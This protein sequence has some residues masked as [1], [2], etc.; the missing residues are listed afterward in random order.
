MSSALA[1]QTKKYGAITVFDLL[2]EGSLVASLI[3]EGPLLVDYSRRRIFQDLNTAIEF[4][5][6]QI[7]PHRNYGVL[8]IGSL[9][10]GN[11]FVVHD[12]CCLFP[13]L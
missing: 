1:V 7:A 8:T 4:Y 5:L 13:L 3:K 6:L 12:S 11:T 10:A 9:S 2:H